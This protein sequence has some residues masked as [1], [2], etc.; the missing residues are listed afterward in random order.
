MVLVLLVH[1]YIF[2]LIF[3][4]YNP[5]ISLNFFFISFILTYNI[6]RPAGK[7]AKRQVPRNIPRPDYADHP[8]GIPEGERIDKGTNTSI[9]VY[10]PQEIEGVREACRIGRECLDIASSIVRAGITCDEIDRVVSISYLYFFHIYT[11]K[12]QIH[13]AII[14]RGAYPSPLNYH[15]FPKSLCTSVNEVVCHGIPGM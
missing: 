3:L 13:E 7:S 5:L 11:Y 8:R 1:W 10:T 9:R 15:C 2:I 12:F 14:E 6:Q 4:L